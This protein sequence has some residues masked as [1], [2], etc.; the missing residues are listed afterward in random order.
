MPDMLCTW[1]ND[2]IIRMTGWA[3]HV[4]MSLFVSIQPYHSDRSSGIRLVALAIYTVR[5]YT[6]Q[7]L[8]DMSILSRLNVNCNHCISADCVLSGKSANFLFRCTLH[9]MRF[10]SELMLS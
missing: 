6:R 1:D 8:R 3:Q 2:T 7:S 9:L 4:I 10:F 5:K